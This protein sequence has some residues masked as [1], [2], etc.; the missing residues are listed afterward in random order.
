MLS[1][2]FIII[3]DS[4]QSKTEVK[5]GARA[6]KPVAIVHDFSGAAD[7]LTVTDILSGRFIEGRKL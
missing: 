3:G 1:D 7:T 5:V 6:N 4:N 2:E